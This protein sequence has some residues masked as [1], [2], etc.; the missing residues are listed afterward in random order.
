MKIKLLALAVLL[1]AAPALA[2]QDLGT[3][4]QRAEGNKL[5]DKYCSQCHGDA[6]DGEGVATPYVLPKPRDFTSGK[7]KIRTTPS[8]QLPTHQDLKDIIRNGMPYSSM[9]A[10]PQFTEAEKA[11]MS[12]EE[13]AD[14]YNAS[15]AQEEDR[16]TCRRVTPTGSHRSKTICRTVSEAEIERDAAQETLRK[17]RGTSYKPGN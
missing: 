1:A 12:T 15:V 11:E 6:G 3:E 9:P 17:G 14:I 10:W 5:Y 7:Y 4:E 13:K 16:V 8:G 2:Q